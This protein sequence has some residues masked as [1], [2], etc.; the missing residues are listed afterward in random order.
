MGITQYLI[1]ELK[2]RRVLYY[3]AESFAAIE[4]KLG[5]EKLKTELFKISTF[6]FSKLKEPLTKFVKRYYDYDANP[7]KG[8]NKLKKIE[9]PNVNKVDFRMNRDVSEIYGLYG[10]ELVPWYVK[11]NT[12]VITGTY[13]F[14]GII[15]EVD[16][17]DSDLVY[18]KIKE[19]L[20]DTD[21]KINTT[22]KHK[23]LITV[24]RITEANSIALVGIIKR[25]DIEES[26][27]S[28]FTFTYTVEFVGI[29]L[30]GYLGD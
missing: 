29:D 16:I 21:K 30:W 17:L 18:N 9:F 22:D 23:S 4:E 24:G 27:E 3:P 5:K 14:G 28:Q 19:D 15:S 26:T 2:D 1:P 7:F 10:F 25:F 8:V 6:N 12:L 20:F 11:A 13:Y